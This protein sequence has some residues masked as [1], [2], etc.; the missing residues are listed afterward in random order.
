MK[1]V[2]DNFCFLDFVPKSGNSKSVYIV[3]NKCKYK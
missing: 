3:K 1:E 2:R